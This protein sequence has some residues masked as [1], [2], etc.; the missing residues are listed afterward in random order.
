LSVRL[1]YTTMNTIIEELLH[2]TEA[3][4]AA[5][6]PAKLQTEDTGKILEKAICDTFEIQFNGP[7]SYSQSEVDKITPRLKRLPEMFPMC[8][9]TASKGAQYDFTALDDSN[10]HLSAKSNKK[11]GG[12]IAP[13]VVGQSSPQKFCQIISNGNV[14]YTTPENLKKHIQE[15]IATIM[16]ILWKYTFDSQILYYVRNT[17]Q[18]SFISPASIGDE[19]LPDWSAF[20]YSWTRP[21]DKWTNSSSLRVRIPGK[22]EKDET[23]MEFQFHTKSRQNMAVRWCIEKVLVLFAEYFNVVSL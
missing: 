23:I 12:K 20:Q 21:Y 18:I 16:P 14:D 13:Q 9:H 3:A 22:N 5:E 10:R 1:L 15:N 19:C 8:S 17:D 2:T 4:A 11:K 6:A 7:F